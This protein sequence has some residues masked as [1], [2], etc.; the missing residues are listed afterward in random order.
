MRYSPAFHLD[1]IHTPLLM[2]VMGFGEHYGSVASLP[3]NLA[4]KWD[5]FSGLN[6]LR[7]PVELYYYPQEDHEI[8]HPKAR[9][10]DLERNLDW[11]RFWLLGQE[12]PDA[13]DPERYSRWRAMR[14]EQSAP[15]AG[16]A[17]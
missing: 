12:R 17:D 3:R 16:A 2:E 15:R 10:A 9:L 14:K 8:V 1:E 13:G 11:Y 7:R 5:L 6:R 4:L